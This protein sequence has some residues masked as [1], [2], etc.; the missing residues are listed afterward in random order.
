MNVCVCVCLFLQEVGSGNKLAKAE[1]DLLEGL[2]GAAKPH[3]DE[4]KYI[5]HHSSSLLCMHLIAV[6]IMTRCIWLSLIC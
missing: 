2:L 6:I 4:G 3:L 5:S 1:L